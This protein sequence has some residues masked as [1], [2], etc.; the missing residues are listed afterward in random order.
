MPRLGARSYIFVHKDERNRRNFFPLEHD[1]GQ[2]RKGKAGERKE[3][4]WIERFKTAIINGGL[5]I[6]A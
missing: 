1:L 6:N 4:W 3:W 5:H 2:E